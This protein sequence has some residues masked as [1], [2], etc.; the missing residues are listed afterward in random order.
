MAKYYGPIGYADFCNVNGRVEERITERLYS[1]DVI[2]NTRRWQTGEQLNDNLNV[3][4]VI[5]IVSDPYAYQNF[6][7]MRYAVW[8][9]AKWKIASAEVVYPRIQLTLGGIYNGD[10]SHSPEVAGGPYGPPVNYQV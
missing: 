2:R 3:N 7:A 5:S 1:G 10:T 4:N 6:H 8:M 9:G